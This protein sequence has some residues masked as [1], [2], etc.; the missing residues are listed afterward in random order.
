MEGF[1]KGDVVVVPFPFSDL[2]NKNLFRKL[3][4][5]TPIRSIVVTLREFYPYSDSF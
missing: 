5:K 1:V 4:K 2:S 3:R